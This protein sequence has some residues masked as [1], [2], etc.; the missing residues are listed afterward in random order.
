[1][2]PDMYALR[3]AHCMY[4]YEKTSIKRSITF[5]IKAN[6]GLSDA[7]SGQKEV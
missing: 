4:I 7:I 5:K 2:T 6:K 3:K 1:M